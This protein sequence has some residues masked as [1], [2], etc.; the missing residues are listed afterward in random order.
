MPAP[1]GRVFLEQ[2]L[3]EVE[4]EVA[5][6]VVVEAGLELLERKPVDLPVR[7][8]HV[9][10][11]LALVLGLGRD[12][13]RRPDLRHLEPLRE[14]DELPQVGARLAGR[15]H[16]LSP[17]L[18]AALGVAVGALLL[19]PH[20]GRQDQVGRHRGDR[21]VDVAHHDEAGRVAE[22]GPD[23]AVDVRAGLHVVVAHHPVGVQ[24]AVLQHPA[25]QHGVIAD[26]V[27]DRAGRQLPDVLGLGAVL[28]VGDHHVRGQPM[29]EGADLARGAARRGLAGERERAVARLGD[30]AGEEVDVVAEL[31]HP[32]AA[33]V[34]VEPHRPGRHDLHLGVGVELGERDELARRHARELLHL[35]RG[36]FGDE[37][38]VRVEVDRLHRLRVLGVLRFLL[39]RV[40]RPQP[41][42]DVVVAAHEVDVLRHEIL[43]HAAGADD[44]VRDEVEDREVGIRR[45]DH[46]QVRELVPAVLIGREHGDLDVR[47]LQ[48]PVGDPRPQDRVHLGHVRAPHDERVGRLDVV[49]A[50]HRLV[51]AER[52][53][54]AGHRRGHAVAGVR[55]E[56]VRP[57]PGLQ[58]L[59]RGVA[60]PHRPLARAEHADGGRAALRERLLPLLGHDVEGF[61]PRHP[62][63]LAVLVV[64]AVLLPEERRREAVGAVHDLREEVALDAVQAAVHF[65]FRVALGRDHAAVLHADE[66]A[67]AGAA[68]AARGLVPADPVRGAL[69][70]GRHCGQGDPRGRGRRRCG[71]GLHELASVDR[72]GAFSSSS[73]VLVDHRGAQHTVEPVQ[74]HDRVGRAALGRVLGGHDEPPVRRLGADLDPAHALELRAHL[75]APARCGVDDGAGDVHGATPRPRSPTPGTPRRTRRSRCSAP[76]PRPARRRCPRRR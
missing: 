42:A 19:H 67:A 10:E 25:L 48:A 65:R 15:L 30:L 29:R 35:L 51:H 57:E 46:V 60:L 31:V 59:R 61:L 27:G 12:E 3:L 24:L 55:V 13:L 74:L 17:E 22:A 44:V 66:H 23:L 32:G 45:E 41:V 69:R 1:E 70:D 26:L 14:L 20:R 54:E 63:E 39:A 34:L 28:R 7:E 6:I 76:R 16:L 73:R 2:P 33:R 9:V 58:Q 75:G 5:R 4:A 40:L 68:E 62:R 52:A 50:A 21:G 37:L 71:V 49:V 64:L 18:G 53:H 11:R 56:V 43:V 38:G 8:Q 72:H 47:V 36:V